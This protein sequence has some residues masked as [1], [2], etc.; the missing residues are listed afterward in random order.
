MA[1][2]TPTLPAGA[3]PISARGRKDELGS[4]SARGRRRR[5]NVL[6]WGVLAVVSLVM[7]APFIW[8]FLTSFRTQEEQVG[9]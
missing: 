2:E 5:T 8:M 1:T 9:S 7:A 6:I 3:E 4:S